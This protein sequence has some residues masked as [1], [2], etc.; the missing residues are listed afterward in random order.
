[1]GKHRSSES[2][3]RH[4][5]EITSV[6]I[7]DFHVFERD[8]GSREITLNE[9]LISFTYQHKCKQRFIVAC[10]YA[11]ALQQLAALARVVDPACF[12]SIEQRQFKCRSVVARTARLFQLDPDVIADN[13]CLFILSM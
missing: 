6:N 10:E 11:Q 12:A 3:S 4:D 5:V 7:E 2:S 1:M 8:G 9:R 13:R